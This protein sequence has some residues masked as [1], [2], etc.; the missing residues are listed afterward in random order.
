[1]Q[2][3]L[4]PLNLFGI[5]AQ[6]A[7]FPEEDDEPC[8][9]ERV[10]MYRCPKCD[11]LHEDEDDAESCCASRVTKKATTTCPVCH[12][13][14]NTHRDAADCCLWKDIDA[15]TRWQI[16]DAVEHGSTWEI[17]LGVVAK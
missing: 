13:N 3:Q 11:E 12:E 10:T 4:S 7:K 17:E 16:A 2:I 1:M 6:L 9:V 14:Y 15:L 5:K 8:Q